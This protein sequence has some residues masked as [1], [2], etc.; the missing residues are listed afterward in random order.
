ME[1]LAETT[2]QIPATN[3]FHTS[4][5]RQKGMA[6]AGQSKQDWEDLK[7]WG[8]IFTHSCSFHTP[9]ERLSPLKEVEMF[10]IYTSWDQSPTEKE[11]ISS[12][13]QNRCCF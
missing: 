11:A 1:E 7:L 10:C 2:E 6:E 13:S 8:G 9:F 4:E 5:K 12:Q 3:P